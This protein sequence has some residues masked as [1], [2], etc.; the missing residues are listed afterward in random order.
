[1]SHEIRT[2]MNGI[3]GMV[4]LVKRSSLSEDQKEMVATIQ[5]SGNALLSLINDILDI[6]KIEA[7]RIELEVLPSDLA[8]VSV[9]ALE[10]IAANAAKNQQALILIQ[11]PLL[12]SKLL[13][14]GLRLRQI[15][16]N[17][18]GNAIK[19]SPLSAEIVVRIELIERQAGDYCD[20]LIRVIDQG[21]GLSAEAQENIFADFA[22]AEKSTSRIYGGTG[23]G[24]AICRRLVEVCR[25]ASKWS[26]SWVK[27]RNLKYSFVCRKHLMLPLS[28]KQSTC[29]GSTCFT[30][31][32]RPAAL[33]RSAAC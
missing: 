23:L 6:S 20:V 21:I 19:F 32:P 7:G 15:L 17:L 8:E 26:A 11:D 10:V 27:G 3:L 33:N 22:Q 2:P 18:A 5:D 30:L 9:S 12:P 31:V 14:D 13:L 1:M 29:R 28:G 4:D 24:L 16:V 25:A